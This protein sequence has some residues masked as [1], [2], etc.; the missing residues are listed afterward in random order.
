[1]E[2]LLPLL[3]VLALIGGYV[4]GIVG[5]FK[6]N[7][8]LAELRALRQALGPTPAAAPKL[9]QASP[10]AQPPIPGPTPAAPE[11]EA[12]ASAAKPKRDIEALLTLRWGVW[13]GAAALL[14]AGVF[15][16]R[17]AVDEGL[18]GPPERCALAAVLGA[19]LIA[20]AE[21]LGRRPA[22]EA[23]GAVPI[24]QAPAGLAAGGVAILFGA[25]YGAGPFYALVP[26]LAGF[27]LL[28]G[29][30]MAGL[31]A[32]LRYGQLAAAVGVAGAFVTPAL[33]QTDTPSLPG[34][35]GYLLAVTAVSLAVVRSS[36][37]TWLGWAATVAGAAWVFLAAL[38][39]TAADAW[40][41]A[42]FVPAA[43]AL[44]LALLP[45]AA[46]DH[47]V[48]RRLS[49]VPFAT[50]GATGLLLEAIAP[51]MAPR[52]GV[53]LLAPLA[54]AKGA[55][56]PRLD[57]L[58]WLAALLFL[59]ALLLWALP[60]WQPGGEAI[61]VEGVVQAVLPGPWAPEAIRPLLTA[62]AVVAGFLAAAGLYLERRAA[63]PL[64]WAALA[65]A[66]PVLTL[67]V[68]YAQVARFQPDIAWAFAALALTAGL[69]GA[70]ARAAREQAR[71]RAGAHAAGA[72][73]ALALG[74]A[75]LLHDHW[76]T[77]AVALFLPP[78]AW[79]EARADLPPLRR[80]A[81]AVAAL[82]LVRLLLNWYVLD[83]QYGSTPV[84]NGL[85]AAYGVPAAAF[86]AAAILFRRRGDDLTVAVLEAGAVA[87]A[88]VLVAL[89][90]R[91]WASSGGLRE[92]GSFL[93]AALH[94]SALG[95]QATA[96]RALARRTGR[97]VL[98][99]GWQI[100]GGLALVGA[101]LLL[102]VNPAFT[103]ASA[104]SAALALA[105]LLPGLLAAL[106]L[107]D[108]ATLPASVPAVLGLYA[109]LAGFAWIGLEI[110]ALFH[111]D[112]LSLDESPV[113]DAELWAWS[114]AWLAYGAGLMALGIRNGGRALRLAGLAII[115]VA[116][117]KVFLVDMADLAGLWRVLSFLALGLILIGLGAVYRR[118]VLPGRAAAEP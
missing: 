97:P 7:R 60:D 82:V 44:N 41:P 85:L 71:P 69:V 95:L 43:A 10:W 72:V 28:A 91:H 84:A 33:V 93:E 68:T 67:A 20:A 110:R 63:N 56:E 25:A 47:P 38:A 13:L 74:C 22:A 99:A 1:M 90:I 29:A 24:D 39:A 31:L 9:P 62:A 26:P 70:A 54:V 98:R 46:L 86:A 92:P 113:E 118:F 77:L 79:I 108:R 76:L 18:L 52:I 49:W 19:A 4:L 57:R 66:V 35:F 75:I 87:F 114:G 73:A 3:L 53:M 105:Y 83:Y 100:Q 89:E 109:I 36:A 61:T 94:V 34:L 12:P 50:L 88:T 103:G 16:I 59:L 115:G 5:F 112:A 58:P 51:G 55:T 15:L 48:G 11:P 111:G 106:A 96:L 40:A 14:M 78:L 116:A 37:W 2:I 30:A 107:R 117:A 42:L 81:L 27:V 64:H 8:A 65:A 21:W 45:P 6:A 17:Y 101:A 23:A 104:G 80:V 102:L 32:S